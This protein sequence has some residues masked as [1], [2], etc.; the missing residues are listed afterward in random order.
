MSPRNDEHKSAIIL[1]Y[2]HWNDKTGYP[3]AMRSAA[4]DRPAKRS[5]KDP[6]TDSL[7]HV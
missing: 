7:A 1:A 5:I 2:P 3:I 4:D 6:R